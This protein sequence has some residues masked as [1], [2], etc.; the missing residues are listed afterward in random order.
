[1]EKAKS[2]IG[3]FVAEQ[4]R[5]L[6]KHGDREYDI[7]DKTLKKVLADVS[8]HPERYP[9]LEVGEGEVGGFFVDIGTVEYDKYV[10]EEFASRKTAGKVVFEKDGSGDVA[11]YSISTSDGADYCEDCSPSDI[12]RIAEAISGG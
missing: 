2:A 1:M 6:R 4:F 11:E 8:G 3:S 5:R 12:M 9:G 7:A 10:D